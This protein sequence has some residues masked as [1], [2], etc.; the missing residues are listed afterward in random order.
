[1]SMDDKFVALGSDRELCI[2]DVENRSLSRPKLSIGP[3]PSVTSQRVNFSLNG[4]QVVMVTRQSDGHI[5]TSLC[6]RLPPHDTWNKITTQ[7]IGMVRPKLLSSET[8]IIM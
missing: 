3:N 4:E 8:L 5:R 6:N 2:F 7:A 1:V